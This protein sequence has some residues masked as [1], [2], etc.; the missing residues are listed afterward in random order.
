MLIKETSAKLGG[1]HFSE[2]IVSETVDQF[3]EHG[4]TF[5]LLELVGL[6]SMSNAFEELQYQ[7][8]NKQSSLRVL[9]NEKSNSSFDLLTTGTDGKLIKSLGIKNVKYFWVD[10]KCFRANSSKSSFHI[11]LNS[12]ITSYL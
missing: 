10:R 8:K 2:Q 4:T 1:G 5:L 6:G 12:T 7:R 3:F 9:F 11:M